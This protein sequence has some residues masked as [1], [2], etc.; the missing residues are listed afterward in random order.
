MIVATP[1]RLRTEEN[2]TDFDGF[3]RLNHRGRARRELRPAA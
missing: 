3:E 2:R 1:L